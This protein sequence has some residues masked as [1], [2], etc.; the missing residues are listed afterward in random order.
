M[1]I[2]DAAFAQGAGE[3]CLGETGAAGGRHGADIDQQRDSGRVELVE[4]LLDRLAFIAD[5][6]ERGLRQRE[7]A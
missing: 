1:K 3:G 4:E 6:R 5:R 2:V 7:R